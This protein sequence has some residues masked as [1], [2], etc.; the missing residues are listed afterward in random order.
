MPALSFSLH[1]ALIR[2]L[3]TSSSPSCRALRTHVPSALRYMKPWL[4]HQV[5]GSFLWW[6]MQGVRGC[7]SGMT[8]GETPAPMS[9]EEGGE[10][11]AQVM[12]SKRVKEGEGWSKVFECPT[13][14]ER[15]AKWKKL[16]HHLKTRQVRVPR[17]IWSS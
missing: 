4:E 16:Q 10:V 1:R 7:S 13:C 5:R 12:N 15:F 14:G 17:S 8:T 11:V 3:L 6:R 9:R 2:P